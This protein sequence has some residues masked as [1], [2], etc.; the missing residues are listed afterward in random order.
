MSID[1]RMSLD[2][3]R[4]YLRIMQKRYTVEDRRGKSV[5]LNEMERITGLHRKYLIG[6]MGSELERK[7]RRKQRGRTYGPEVDDALRVIHESLDYICAERLTPSLVWMA[8]HLAAHD[9]LEIS[10]SLLEQ[11]D[12]ISVSTVQRILSRIGQDQPRLPRKGPRRANR[13]TRDVPMKRIAW[14]EQEPGH[15]EVDLVHHSGPSA[16]GEFV[17]TLQMID[18]ATGWSERRAVLG[19]S[20]LVMEDAFRCILRRLPFPVLEIHPDNGSE[21]FNDILVR[22]WKKII[23]GVRM[24]RSRPYQKNDNRFVEQKNAT[25]VRRYLGNVRLDTVNQTLALNHLYDKMWL[26]YN[27]FQPVMRLEQKIPMG[28]EGRITHIKRR[29]DQAQTPFH[30]LC[31]TNTITPDH[32]QQ[33]QALRDSINPRELREEIHDLIDEL[34]SLPGAG[35]GAKQNVHL[36]LSHRSDR[37]E[38]ENG[39]YIL[40]FNRSTVLEDS[41][42]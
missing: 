28:E 2:E 9:E 36:T 6:L 27:L 3:R 20:S 41:T 19:R 14:D 40:L 32:R 29:Y 31:K 15:F 22:F 26:Y 18:V 8:Q 11:L 24:S 39:A 37:H 38:E 23:K 4:K 10:F 25:L 17:C 33:L 42:L 30:R 21:F 16:A 34:F 7:L 5:L 35:P 1:E 13:I 12:K